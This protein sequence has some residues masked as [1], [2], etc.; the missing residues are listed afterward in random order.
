MIEGGKHILH[1]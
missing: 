1:V